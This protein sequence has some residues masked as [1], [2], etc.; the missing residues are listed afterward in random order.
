M[1]QAAGHTLDDD[2]AL[3]L[4][5]AVHEET[6]GNPFFV[7]EVLRHLTETGGI[8]Q[9]DGRWVTDLPI[10]DLGIPEGVRDVVG[11]RLSRLSAE[12]N[13]LL[14]VAAVIGLEFEL[15]VLQ[16]AA[17]LTENALISAVEDA[18]AARLVADLPGPGARCRFA[19][20]LVRDTLYAEFSAA[21]RVALHRRVAE[22]IE[23]VHGAKL[24]GHLPALAYHYGRAAAPAADTL[25]A[26]SYAAQ[27][28]DDALA[29]L[30]HDEAA[31][32]YAQALEMLAAVD[33]PVDQAQRQV[34]LI[35]LGEA[36]RRAGDPTHR[37]TLLEAADL[38]RRRG[39]AQGLARA[40]LANTRGLLPTAFG[41]VDQ[42]KVAVLEAAI[43]AAGEADHRARA[44]LLAT[45]GVELIF[46]GD[47]RRCLALSDE[48]VGLAR[49]TGDPPTLARV[50]VARYFPTSAPGLLDERL[51]DT[52][53]LLQIADALSDPAFVAEAHLLRGRAAVEAGEMTEA[54]RCFD[55][56][57]RLAVGLGQPALRWRVTYVR[58]CRA[59]IAGRLADA[60]RLLLESRDWGDQAGQ[61]DAVWVFA[62]EM[63]GLRFQQGRLDPGTLSLVEAAQRTVDVPWNQSV[64]AVTACELGRDDEARAA[65]D[66]S[67]TTPV[68]FDIYWLPAMTRWA[69]VAVHLRATGHAQ[70]LAAALRPYATQVIPFVA[71]PTPSVAHHL[72]MLAAVLRRYDEA[73][74]HFAAAL[75]IHERIVAPLW[76]AR[77]NLEWARMLSSRRQ[78]GDVERAGSL[79]QAAQ[80]A[81]HSLGA[82]GWAERAAAALHSL[83][84]P[85]S[86]LPGGLTEREAEVV[87]L[88]ASGKANKEIA[89][90]LGLSQK[91]VERH[92]SNIFAKLGVSSRAAA[93]SFAHRE[94]IV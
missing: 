66:R 80:G 71:E 84:H 7:V 86:R 91:T 49:S 76:V 85:K 3:A 16:A 89:S 8:Y 56:A 15:P 78:P 63:W 38:A 26:V 82:G 60:E 28:G 90:E 18:A 34:L 23:T 94:G 53:E 68:P 33:G 35:S 67:A 59:L 20:A 77:T 32:Y 37:E 57:E 50:L 14:G 58:A 5:D 19:H 51:R 11:R 52:A 79:L 46:S 65:L 75:A 13:H 55:V 41:R 70:R 83:P 72:G 92:L 24:A 12:V 22:A 43:A 21:R 6:E 87:R 54:D 36:R 48:A 42:E 9:R 61:L 93:T 40:A 29:Q 10:E 39:D 27:A 74:G 44:A 31:E 2:A 25:K 1:E 81:F 64:N 17:G 30:A 4:A 73:E 69:E 45:L 88:V 47:W 62:M